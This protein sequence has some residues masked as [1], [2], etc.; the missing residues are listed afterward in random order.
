LGQANDAYVNCD[1]AEARAIISEV[2]RI[3]AETQE[4]WMI[5]SAIEEDL[6]DMR[7]AVY[8]RIMGAMLRPKDVQGWINTAD[9][10]LAQ[11][12]EESRQF[13]LDIAFYSYCSAVRASVDC[14][15]GRLGK[16]EIKL[17]R[18]SLSGAISDYKRIFKYSP[19]NLKVVR[20][21]GFAY[22]EKGEIENAK[23]LYKSTFDYLR[24]PS[25]TAEETFNWTDIS[26]YITLLQNL[27]EFQLA[28]SELKSLSRWLL[29]RESEAFFDSVTTNDCEW[30]MDDSRRTNI[31]SFTVGKFPSD[32][33]GVSIPPELRV[34]IALCRLKM[35]QEEEAIVRTP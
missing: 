8:C 31:P 12:E 7:N 22:F 13:F 2:I 5:L 16:A 25:T 21:L 30:D 35:G 34:K 3:N 28:I 29:G 32:Y 33:Y 27:D 6:G 9:Y 15:A 23:Q 20:R 24:L 19:H 10:A 11:T 17:E 4:A 18:G 14:V 26:V 1:Y